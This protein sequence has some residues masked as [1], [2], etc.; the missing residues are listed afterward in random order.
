MPVVQGLLAGDTT[1]TSPPRRSTV[2]AK[3]SSARTSIRAVTSPRRSHSGEPGVASGLHRRHGRNPC[4]WAAAA[5][6]KNRVFSGLG[7]REGQLG[8]Q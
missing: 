2:V 5:V 7:V 6:G 1:V 8:L 3:L 4:V